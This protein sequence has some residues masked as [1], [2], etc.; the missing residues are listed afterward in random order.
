MEF[1]KNEMVTPT[2]NSDDTKQA[3]ERSEIYLEDQ[4]KIIEAEK[5]RENLWVIFQR[6]FVNT[7]KT[8]WLFFRHPKQSIQFLFRQKSF[9]IY[10]IAILSG[11]V[12]AAAA[13][14]FGNYISLTRILFYGLIYNNTPGIGRLFMIV[15]LSYGGMNL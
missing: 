12:G 1:E 10:L 6:G 2:N 8:I 5:K 14:V 9:L 7:L 3:E 11:L 13:W 4:S 15:L